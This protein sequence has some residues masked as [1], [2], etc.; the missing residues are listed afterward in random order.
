MNVLTQ[1]TQAHLNFNTRI[2][3]NTT[4]MDNKL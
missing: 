1:T 3:I 2:D 4:E